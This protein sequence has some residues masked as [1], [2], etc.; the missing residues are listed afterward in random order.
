MQLDRPGAL[1]VLGDPDRLVPAALGEQQLGVARAPEPRPVGR[2]GARRVA[3][4]RR[5]HLEE[6]VALLAGCSARLEHA[7][8]LAALGRALA[9]AGRDAEAAPVLAEACELAERCGAAGLARD[10]ASPLV[11]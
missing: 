2:A 1:D 10:L 6:A 9:A 3:F 5:A 11:D 8:A 7:K 4:E